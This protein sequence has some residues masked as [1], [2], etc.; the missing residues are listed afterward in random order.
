M[1]IIYCF[2][3]SSIT[4]IIKIISKSN[5]KNKT[6]IIKYC[7]EKGSR[8]ITIELNPHSNSTSFWKLTCDLS[9]IIEKT[10]ES[11]NLTINID[12]IKT[13]IN[14]NNFLLNWKFNVL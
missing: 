1:I 7:K 5:T 6:L 12:V 4:G 9:I 11:I 13:I 14:L 2:L 8:F 3:D 10:K